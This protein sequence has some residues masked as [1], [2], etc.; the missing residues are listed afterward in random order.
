MSCVFVL[1]AI[2]EIHKRRGAPMG[3]VIKRS[4]SLHLNTHLI[5]HISEENGGGKKL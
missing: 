5:T 4:F 3:V 1:I 2:S